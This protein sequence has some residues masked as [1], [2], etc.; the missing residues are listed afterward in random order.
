[1]PRRNHQRLHVVAPAFAAIL[2]F[3]TAFPS[4][5]QAQESSQEWLQRCASQQG[6]NDRVSYCEV[7][8]ATMAAP[9]RLEVSARPNGGI[10]V[11]GS[12][13]SVVGVSARVQAWGESEAEA[14]E[15]AEQIE[16]QTD[17]GRVSATGPRTNGDGRGWS[18][19]YVIA[20]PR[21]IDLDLGSVNGGI[22]VTGVEGDLSLNTTNG[23][24]SMEGVGGR[25]RGQ[26]TNGG[27][28]VRLAGERWTG[29]GL[30]LRTTNGAISLSVPANFAADLSASTVHGGIQIDFPITVQGR[31][32]RNVDGEIG[33][34]GPPVRLSTT[35]GGIDIRRN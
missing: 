10:E 23:S 26:T 11:V 29:E 28:D 31:I 24:I 3:L 5:G 30:E 1:M 35:N 16:L 15:L 4:A 27:L 19:S 7:R 6:D 32:G 12:D 8:E 14:R 20:A 17:N 18:V 33:G 9:R 22:A 34:G 21:R 13:R 2:A 25:V